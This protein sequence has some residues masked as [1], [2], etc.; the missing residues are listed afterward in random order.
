MRLYFRAIHQVAEG[1]GAAALAALLQEAPVMG[2]RTVGVVLSG[3][4]ADR[5]V[6]AGVLEMQVG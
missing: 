4:N 1:A 2:G 6:Y 3:G 5:E